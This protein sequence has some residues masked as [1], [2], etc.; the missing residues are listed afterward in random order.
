LHFVQAEAWLRDD[1][2]VFCVISAWPGRQYDICWRNRYFGCGCLESATF[3]QW[4]PHW[5]V[6][7]NGG[8][9]LF[10]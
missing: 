8:L 10:C 4:H 7:D 5:Y 2:G 1:V 9:V 3:H 6:C